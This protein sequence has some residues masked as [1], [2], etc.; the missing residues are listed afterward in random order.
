MGIKSYL[1]GWGKEPTN[2]YEQY[3]VVEILTQGRTTFGQQDAHAVIWETGTH[4]ILLHDTPD[5]A[6]VLGLISS[7]RPMVIGKGKLDLVIPIYL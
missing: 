1:Q 5:I 2:I 6:A 7:R 3:E 4:D